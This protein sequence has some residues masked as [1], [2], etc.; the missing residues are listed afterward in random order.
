MSDSDA[1]NELTARVIACRACP[2]LVAWREEVAVKKRRAYQDW[3]YWG[4]P[5]PG[6]GDPNAAARVGNATMAQRQAF[7]LAP[8]P[9]DEQ[10]PA[11]ITALSSNAPNRIGRVFLQL[12]Q[13]DVV[14]TGTRW[15]AAS[16]DG[17]S[18]WRVSRPR[19]DPP[20]GR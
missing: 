12:S 7:D 10:P 15:S 1:L 11:V 6:F 9:A 13:P 16:A 4:K 14:C 2:R 8:D 19:V 5:V 20:D 17:T 18:G 3:E